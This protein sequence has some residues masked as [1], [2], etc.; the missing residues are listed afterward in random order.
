MLDTQRDPDDMLT[1]SLTGSPRRASSSA[2][3]GGEAAGLGD[4]AAK[5]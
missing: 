3:G 5:L 4:F 1:S 2:S